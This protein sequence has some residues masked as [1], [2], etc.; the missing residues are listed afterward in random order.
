MS[1]HEFF[2]DDWFYLK[3]INVVEPTPGVD[4]EGLEVA[5]ECLAEAFKLDSTSINDAKPDVLIDIF[6]SLD[7]SED[8]K[9]KSDLSHE[10]ASDNATASPSA[11]D[12]GDSWIKEPHSN[13][14]SKDELFGQFFSTLEKIQFLKAMPNGDDDPAQLDKATRLFEDAVN[15]ME[16]SGCQTFDRK[17]LVED[18][19]AMGVMVQL[20]K[21]HA[22][23]VGKSKNNKLKLAGVIGAATLT[24][25]SLITLTGG[26]KPIT[27]YIGLAA[28]A[29]IHGL[30]VLAPTLGL[31]PTVEDSHAPPVSA[32][33]KA[34][35][36]FKRIRGMSSP[37]SV[38]AQQSAFAVDVL[39]DLYTFH[40]STGNSL[41]P[42][43]TPVW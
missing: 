11:H 10:G 41:C 38:S 27:L 24:G 32:F 22:V 33:P 37:V 29:I 1:D 30:S 12:F 34:P 14:V 6:S 4:I 20:N 18:A 40:C 43:R 2:V 23:E 9:V 3:I 36:S 21:E 17:D 25:G 35:L 5:R 16:R 7:G 15:E 8:K 39:S 31:V 19:G 26:M 28:P 42:Y 13:G